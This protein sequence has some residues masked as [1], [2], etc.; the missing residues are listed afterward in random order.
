MN[1]LKDNNIRVMILEIPTSVM[2]YSSLGNDTASLLMEMANNIMIEVYSTIAQQET[3]KRAKRQAEGIEAMRKSGNFEKYG[4]QTPHQ[5]SL[6]C[7]RSYYIVI[8]IR[9]N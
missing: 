3:E 4:R 5:T 2:N 1:W 6:M 9:G 7:G 8:T